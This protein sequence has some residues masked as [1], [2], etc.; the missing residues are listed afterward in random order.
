[1]FLRGVVD[2]D[3]TLDNL[4]GVLATIWLLAEIRDV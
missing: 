3:L 4:A 2:A 1:M